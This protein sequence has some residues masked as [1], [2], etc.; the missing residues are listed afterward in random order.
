MVWLLH[1]PVRLVQKG[2]TS[3]PPDHCR[4]GVMWIGVSVSKHKGRVGCTY[5]L[6]MHPQ[7]LKP[8]QPLPAGCMSRNQSGGGGSSH[9][10]VE[11]H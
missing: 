10:A 4:L 7:Q 2:C 9:G 8:L 5:G 11:G 6:L 3:V 1:M